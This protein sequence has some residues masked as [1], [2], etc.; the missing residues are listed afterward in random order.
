MAD[1][2]GLT[3]FVHRGNRYNLKIRQCKQRIL[4]PRV[5]VTTWESADD[6]HIPDVMTFKILDQYDIGLG[7]GCR[8]WVQYEVDF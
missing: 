2:C 4:V 6:V 7:M 3:F 8:S 5:C 1:V